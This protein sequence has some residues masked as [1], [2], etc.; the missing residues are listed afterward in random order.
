MKRA[1]VIFSFLLCSTPAQA[2]YFDNSAND[3]YGRC[4][5]A[6]TF[7]TACIATAASYLDMMSALGYRCKADNV[8]RLQTKDV[9][10]K[11]LVEHPEIRNAPLPFSAI[12]AFETAFSC[13][14]DPPRKP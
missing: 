11:Y 13:K 10:V 2:S 6:K 3:Y 9:L 14:V 1:L 7:D 8:N 5:S 12:L 4:L